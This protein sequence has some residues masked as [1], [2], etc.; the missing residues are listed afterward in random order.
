MTTQSVDA[1]VISNNY[2]PR[3]SRGF[4]EKIHDLFWFSDTH[5]LEF[6]MSCYVGFG[7]D[8]TMHVS[9]ESTAIANLF[10]MIGGII[11]VL[12]M[13][14][15]IKGSLV[16]RERSITILF[17]FQIAVFVT[18]VASVGDLTKSCIGVT[19]ILLFLKWRLMR[20]HIYRDMK[21]RRGK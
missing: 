1:T 19:I 2:T 6:F 17:S 5:L 9:T 11:S 21:D 3:P 10:I 12:C 4:K 13:Y 15:I 20:E 8:N 18:S 14:S 7:Q 16:E